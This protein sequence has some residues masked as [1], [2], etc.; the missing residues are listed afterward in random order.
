M[1]GTGW[2]GGVRIILSR[3]DRIG[4]VII[5]TSCLPSVRRTFP[6]AEILFLVREVMRPL[7]EGLPYVD[8]VISYPTE[9]QN[10]LDACALHFSEV[11]KGL[12]ADTIVH[13]HNDPMVHGAAELAEIPKRVGFIQDGGPDH[14]TDAVPYSKHEGKKHEAEY[15]FDLLNLIGVRREGVLRGEV[16]IDEEAQAALKRKVDWAWGEREFIVI[17]PTAFSPTVRWP[18]ERFAEV[19]RWIQEKYGFH[20]V[21]LSDKAEDPDVVRCCSVLERNGCEVSSLA[22]RLSL[23]E[24]LALLKGARLHFSRSTGTTH[25][26]AAVGCPC[27][28]LFGQSQAIYGPIRWRPLDDVSAVVEAKLQKPWWEPTRRFWRRSMLSITVDAVVERLE[29][30][31]GRI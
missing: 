14:L 8:G 27:L 26:A 13:L 15:N 11:L 3:P 24:V 7:V 5:T 16:V 25:M 20:L 9:E 31:M 22:G 19:G 17:N 4:D 1:S 6:D 10:E 21:I 12:D 29:A 2:E 28:V 23:S 18:A 30:L